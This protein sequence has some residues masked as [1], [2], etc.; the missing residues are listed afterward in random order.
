MVSQKSTK[1]TQKIKKRK[2]NTN[3]TLKKTRKPQGKRLKEEERN[4]ELQKKPKKQ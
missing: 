3:I 2:R 1:Y 4:R